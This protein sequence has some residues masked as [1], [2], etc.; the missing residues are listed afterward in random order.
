M[1]S[2]SRSYPVP[3]PGFPLT[4]LND[5][6]STHLSKGSGEN[7]VEC[8]TNVD[9]LKKKTKNIEGKVSKDIATHTHNLTQ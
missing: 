6:K 3:R 7:Q 9:I 2:S 4:N 5:T 1:S 8:L